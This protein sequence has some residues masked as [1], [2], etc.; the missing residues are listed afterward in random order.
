MGSATTGIPVG[1]PIAASAFEIS[2]FV[3]ARICED[4]AIDVDGDGE[5]LGKTQVRFKVLLPLLFL[6]F[7]YLRKTSF[8]CFFVRGRKELMMMMM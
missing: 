6:F 2:D 5:I 3:C 1:S 7:C 8:L 4:D